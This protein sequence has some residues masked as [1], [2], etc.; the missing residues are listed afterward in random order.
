MAQS[1]KIVYL[2]YLIVW[3]ASAIDPRFPQDWLLENLLVFFLFP[4]VVWLDLRYRLSLISLIFLLIFGSLHAL[5]AHFTYARMEY[6]DVV[7]ELFDLQRNDY[8]RVVHFLFGLLIFRPMYEVVMHYLSS[9]RAALLFA[10]S[11]IVTISTLYE[12]LEW[13][14]AIVFHPELGIAFLGTQGDVW[15]SQKDILVAIIGALINV[16]FFYRGYRWMLESFLDEKTKHS[17]DD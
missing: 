16:L 4:F 14:A 11:M 17:T 3:I 2:I 6:F 5:G 9:F 1:H 8:D 7:T 12:I 15:D 13:L 10:F